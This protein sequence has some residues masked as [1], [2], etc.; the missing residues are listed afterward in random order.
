MVKRFVIITGAFLLSIYLTAFFYFSPS[1]SIEIIN[2]YLPNLNIRYTEGSGNILTGLT[3][4]K[5]QVI[6]DSDEI[7]VVNNFKVSFEY[8]PLI[9][10]RISIDIKSD[11][12]NGKINITFFGNL[13]GE[14]T[15]RELSF[16]T[17]S[18][19]FKEYIQFSAKLN[20]KLNIKNDYALLEIKTEELNWRR[21]SISGV[22]LPFSLFSSAKGGILFSKSRIVIKSINFEGAKGNARIV[23]EVIN[24]SPKLELE[25]IP[26]DWT[27]PYL[28][29]LAQYKTG[30]GYYKISFSM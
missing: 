2:G 30:P 22:E 19:S 20:G 7:L 16:D 13:D 12:V 11:E 9:T 24:N 21:L 26:K 8:L 6:K 14:I 18:Y 15:L 25:I 27:E 4:K 17:A 23:G 29:P 1:V 10:G 5:I 28:I 3:F